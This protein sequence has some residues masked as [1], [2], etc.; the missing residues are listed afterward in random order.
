[1]ENA[2]GDSNKLRPL[3]DAFEQQY[4]IHV[5]L[6]GIPWD[7]GWTDIAQYG[8]YGNGPDISSIGT[9]WVGSLAAMQALRPFTPQEVR[10]MGGHEAFFDA[11]W[12]SGFLPSD[13]QAW[14]IPWLG[15]VM[16]LYYW[17]EAFEKA[18]IGDP[19]EALGSDAAI[20]ETLQK[21]QACGYP[22]PLSL[23]TSRI[24]V[25]LHETAYWIWNA[26]GD[27]M[28]PDQTRVAFNQPAAL[29]GLKKYFNLRPFISPEALALHSAEDMFIEHKSAIVMSGPLP[30]TTGRQLHPEWQDQLGIARLPGKA[31]VGGTSFVIW[32]YSRHPK[33]AFDLVRFLGHQPVHFPASPH[34][35]QLPVRREVIG[36][37]ITE[38]DAFNR[39]YVHA[40]Q[41]GKG[42]P[43]IRLWGS[44]EGKLINAIAAIWA[45]R[46]AHPDDD[47]DTCLHKYLDPLAQRM[48]VVLGN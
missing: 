35:H 45:E 46:Y 48:D 34:N 40:L 15:D 4:H 12:L 6:T 36:L 31:F 20:L 7:Q 14:A 13:S 21:L 3:L 24:P 22:Y 28:T 47:L 32:K 23:T 33:E 11:N 25:I 10:D 19:A 27:F 44:L 2:A 43:T 5:N 39:A 18:A 8:I 16:V 9:T 30:G 29:E 37:S 42:F 26:G 1:M 17:K 38:N 41:N